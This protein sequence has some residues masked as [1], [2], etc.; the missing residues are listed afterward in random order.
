MYYVYILECADGGS[1]TGCTSDLKNR[2]EKHRKG[3]VLATVNRLPI[4]LIAY[5]GF[6]NRYSAFKFEKYLKSGSGR[7]FMKRHLISYE[8]L[9]SN[10]NI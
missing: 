7:S 2:I 6:Q 3:Q 8:P 10:Q 1:Y 4:K 5:I 9:S